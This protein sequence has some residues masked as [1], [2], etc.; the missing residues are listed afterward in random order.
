MRVQMGCRCGELITYTFVVTN[1]GNVTLTNVSI[2]DPLPG[3]STITCPSGTTNPN[4]ERV[5]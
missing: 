5:Q 4:V 1:T 2:T 3:R